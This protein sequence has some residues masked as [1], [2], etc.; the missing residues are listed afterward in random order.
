MPEQ[1]ETRTI[2]LSPNGELAKQM[3]DLIAERWVEYV[4][5]EG[6]YLIQSFSAELSQVTFSAET[7]PPQKVFGEIRDILA[8]ADHDQIPDDDSRWSLES[9]AFPAPDEHGEI[10]LEVWEE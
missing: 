8:D 6:N 2:E 4:E 1:I 7:L 9:V 10:E 3:A 5:A